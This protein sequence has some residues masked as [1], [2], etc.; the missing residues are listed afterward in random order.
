MTVALPGGPYAA[1]RRPGRIDD[2]GCFRVRDACLGMKKTAQLGGGFHS[3]F[4]DAMRR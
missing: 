4:P 2:N 3:S 1:S